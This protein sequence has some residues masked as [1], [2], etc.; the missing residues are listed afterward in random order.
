[1]IENMFF[2]NSILQYN[3]AS[4]YILSS[5]EIRNHLFEAIL[6]AAT[7]FKFRKVFLLK[8]LGYCTKSFE[9]SWL[10]GFAKLDVAALRFRD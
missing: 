8:F 5:V 10:K 4:F 1:M 7:G 6:K 3:M 9:V 2:E